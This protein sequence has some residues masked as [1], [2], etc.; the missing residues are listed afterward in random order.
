MTV[1]IQEQP[2]P[3]AGHAAGT[4]ATSAPASGSQPAI[5]QAHAWK[6][7]ALAVLLA[8]TTATAAGLGAF[9][10]GCRVT[11]GAADPVIWAG[12]TFAAVLTLVILVEEKLGLY[13]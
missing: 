11:E 12:A 10:V 4:S 9:V 13:S 2:D 6:V 7:R 5:S 3:A 8:L 1:H